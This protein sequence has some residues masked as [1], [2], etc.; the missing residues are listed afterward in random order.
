MHQ[1]LSLPNEFEI[2]IFPFLEFPKSKSN[3][4]LT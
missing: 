3:H 1:K 4:N 2:P